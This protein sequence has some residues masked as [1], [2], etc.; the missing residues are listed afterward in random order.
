[1]SLASA[2]IH[3][4]QVDFEVP[5]T[6]ATGTVSLSVAITDWAAP[7]DECEGAAQCSAAEVDLP[8]ARIA[9]LLTQ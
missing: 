6:L 9:A 7:I 1:M 3:D 2:D 8:P 4:G 5:S